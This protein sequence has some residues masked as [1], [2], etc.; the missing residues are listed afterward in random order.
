MYFSSII[1]ASD[2]HQKSNWDPSGWWYILGVY[3]ENSGQNGI[4]APYQLSSICKVKRKSWRD[5]NYSFQTL[6]I[7]KDTK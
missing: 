1:F 6:F 2:L 4:I 3:G 7:R 5:W